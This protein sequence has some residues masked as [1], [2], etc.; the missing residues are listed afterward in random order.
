MY[1]Q[2]AR[3]NALALNFYFTNNTMPTF[4]SIVCFFEVRP[5]AGGV[6][7]RLEKHAA[8]RLKILEDLKHN[9]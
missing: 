2:L 1:E 6:G 3:K 4:T 5:T 9:F 7:L 8:P